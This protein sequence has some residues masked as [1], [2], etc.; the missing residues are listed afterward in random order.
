MTNDRLIELL[1]A[2]EDFNEFI[3]RLQ[4]ELNLDHD[5]AEAEARRI[6]NTLEDEA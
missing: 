4:D 3:C 5:E 2:S 1:T 6:V